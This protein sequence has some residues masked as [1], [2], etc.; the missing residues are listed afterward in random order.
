MSI[1]FAM[2]S[3]R[4]QL[5]I[6]SFLVLE[7]MNKVSSSKD[8]MNEVK[9]NIPDERTLFDDL[10]ANYNKNIRP[11]T[12]H[13]EVTTVFFEIALFTVLSLNTRDQKL[14]TNNE[15]IMKWDDNF[16]RWNPADYNDT[17]VIRVPYETIW[18]PD[19]ILYN[20]A[21]SNYRVGLIGTNAIICYTGEVELIFHAMFQSTCEIDISWYP[22]DQQ[23]CKMHFSSMTYDSTKLR[24]VRAPAD[25]S[26]YSPHPEFYLEN[27]YSELS[28]AYDPC[29]ANPFSTV[30]YHVQLQ[31]RTMFAVYFFIMPGTIVNICALLTFLLPAE[32]GEKISLST[33]ALL[34]M[35]VFLMAMTQD[36]PPTEQVPLIGRYYGG[37]IFLLSLNIAASV[38]TLRCFFTSDTP[39]PRSLC[40]FLQFLGRLLL[41]SPPEEVR[42]KWELELPRKVGRTSNGSKADF[43]RV[44]PNKEDSSISFDIYQ[45]RSLEAL[46]GI[47]LLLL[48]RELQRTRGLISGNHPSTSS[49]YSHEW[50]Y[51]SR[52]LD[53]F[54][55]VLSIFSF[56]I[57][58][59]AVLLS[60][61][62]SVKL[63][64]CPQG[65]GTC[66]GSWDADENFALLEAGKGL[67]VIPRN[68]RP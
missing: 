52:I 17:R 22:F 59:L 38:F 39:L 25:L 14:M 62:H 31:R 43:I 66:P 29:C 21:D 32:S 53:R 24:L 3:S 60:S 64:Y 2:D 42:R 37:C 45:Q 51:M 35:M 46:E 28:D 56:V 12:H 48:D 30:I 19:V 20:T 68:L 44:E 10:F 33:N 36:I 40:I 15:M 58:N 1:F 6:I 27:F 61:P 5:M 18:Y 57:F 47:H 41:F 9:A 23:D 8:V 50:R 26:Q 4:L 13:E 54:F 55:L 7:T 65:P 49:D 11:V 16:L 34:A 63:E 67:T